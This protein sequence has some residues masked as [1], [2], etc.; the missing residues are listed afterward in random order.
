MVNNKFV[1]SVDMDFCCT[2]L[3]MNFQVCS[4]QVS[5]KMVSGATTVRASVPAV[6]TVPVTLLVASVYA[7]LVGWAVTAHKVST[8]LSFTTVHS[9]F[10]K[11]LEPYFAHASQCVIKNYLK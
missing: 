9:K 4:V 7:K 10:E 8:V 6:I 2:C 11:K 3:G 1:F 5:V